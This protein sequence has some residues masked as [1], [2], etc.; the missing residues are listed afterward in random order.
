M[1]RE[2]IEGFVALVAFGAT[3]PMANWMIGNVGTVCVPNGPC[4]IPV[5]PTI[6]A[7]SGVLMV[8]L[9]LVLRDLVQRRLGRSWSLAA[10]V[11][12]AIASAVVAPP[13]LV[14]A[15]ATAFFLSELADFAV[16]TPLQQR[17][18]V[19]AVVASC[20]V[21]LTVDSLVFLY[22]A[23]GSL[24]YLA[25]QIIGKTWMVLFSVP[26][27]RWIRDRDLRFGISPA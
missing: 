4:L 20:L 14:L 6:T 22:L 13:A 24:D 5:V 1:R 11:A 10:I 9:A 23:F 18:L 16:Y 19:L 12:G 25:G 21:G 8:G 26:V 2:R 17:R 27:V 3:I 15:S 7:P